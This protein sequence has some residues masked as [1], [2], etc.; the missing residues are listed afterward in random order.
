MPLPS[1]SSRIISIDIFLNF[2]RLVW[3]SENDILCLLV[4]HLLL[5]F[6]ELSLAYLVILAI[7]AHKVDHRIIA[8][9]PVTGP[10]VRLIYP[11]LGHVLVSEGQM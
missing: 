6:L 7:F 5:E 8:C 2:L 9:D 1:F 4:G 11:K 10:E 3:I